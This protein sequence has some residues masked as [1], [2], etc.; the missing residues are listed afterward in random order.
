MESTLNLAYRDCPNESSKAIKPVRIFR[1]HRGTGTPKASAATVAIKSAYFS[2]TAY[3]TKRADKEKQNS[4]QSQVI[5]LERNPA[6][7]FNRH[8]SLKILRSKQ[9]ATSENKFKKKLKVE[10]YTFR[11][12][13][14]KALHGVKS[15]PLLGSRSVKGDKALHNI[16]SEFI[17][18]QKES[19][20]SM[21]KLRKIKSIFDINMRT[22]KSLIENK[23]NN[24][25]KAV[26]RYVKYV[27]EHKPLFIYGPTG[28]GRYI[29]SKAIDPLKIRDVLATANAHCDFLKPRLAEFYAKYKGVI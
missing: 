3:G 25:N 4:E 24:D 11:R 29:D 27:K 13:T 21:K 8:A 22:I 15:L 16:M 9:S 2:H 28:A 10:S 17:K 7:S 23:P 6:H 14:S 19:K 1:M 20:G 26:Q 12:P 18:E 5:K